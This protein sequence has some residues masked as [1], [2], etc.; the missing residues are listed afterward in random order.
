MMGG[1]K[2]QRKNK[3]GHELIVLEL[4]DGFMWDH[5]IVYLSLHLDIF[6]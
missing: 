1:S 2:G 4:D 3:K 6:K 5:H